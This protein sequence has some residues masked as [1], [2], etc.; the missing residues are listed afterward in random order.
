MKLFSFDWFRS[1]ERKELQRLQVDAQRIKNQLLTKQLLPP[2]EEVAKKP[3][4]K[5]LYTNGSIT[6]VFHDGVVITKKGCDAE[7]F[8]RAKDAY[9]DDVLRTLLL[10]APEL[11]K[12]PTEAYTKE[13]LQLVKANI[14]SVVEHEDFEAIEDDIFLKGVK[15]PIPPIV[16]AS[17]IE[18]VEKLNAPFVTNKTELAEK[19]EALKMFWRWTALNPIE[20]SRNDLYTFIKKNDISITANGLLPLYRRVVT[21]GNSNKELVKFISEEYARI[22]RNKKAPK[23]YNVLFN[24]K[25]GYLLSTNNTAAGLIL[26]GGRELKGNLETLY[27]DLPN[28]TENIYTDGRT[29][30]MVIKIGEIYKESEDKID[31]DNTKECSRGLHVGSRDFGFH[32]FGDTGVMALVNPM[33]VRSVPLADSY[34]MRVSEMFIVG[35]MPLEEYSK[36]IDDGVLADYSNEYF[37]ESVK[38]LEEQL[39]TRSYEKLSCQENVPALAIVDIKSITESLKARI[40][41]I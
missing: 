28:M 4:K 3:Y 8:N 7:C 34:K 37:N 39:A 35:V 27:L 21:V 12:Q 33:K 40:V 11:V 20:S 38:E 16:L 19:F 32:G 26:L 6:A 10:P 23:N 25:E 29:R 2:P 17:F 22:K 24:E 30:K 13:E 14:H 36:D 1:E 9:S 5:L 41:K 18:L 31:L 15:L